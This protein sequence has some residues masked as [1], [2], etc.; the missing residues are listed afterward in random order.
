MTLDDF[1]RIT[2]DWPATPFDYRGVAIE[3]AAELA[4]MKA[5]PELVQAC[6]EQ[7]R[8]HARDRGV[9]GLLSSGAK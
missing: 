7:F 2:A 4:V 1:T 5:R 8:S 3:S 6:F 9:I